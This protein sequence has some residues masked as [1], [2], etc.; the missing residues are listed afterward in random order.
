MCNRPSIAGDERQ[1][2]RWQ[3]IRRIDFPTYSISRSVFVQPSPHTS[4]S[5]LLPGLAVLRPFAVR[6]HL[7]IDCI[8]Y[9]GTG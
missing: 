2:P 5:L 3:P 7:Q 1:R 9:Y 8:S 4:A 6:Y